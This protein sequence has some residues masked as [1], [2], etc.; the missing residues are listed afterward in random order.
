MTANATLVKTHGQGC[1]RITMAWKIRGNARV[2]VQDKVLEMA[3]RTN[4]KHE[5]AVVEKA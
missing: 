4:S 1:L 2:L 5:I 3:R